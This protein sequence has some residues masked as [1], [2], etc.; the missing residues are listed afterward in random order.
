MSK[1]KGNIP[2]QKSVFSPQSNAGK[3]ITWQV[4][5][6][7]L[8]LLLVISVRLRLLSLPLERDEGQSAYIGQLLLKGYAPFELAY[9]MKFPGT[10]IMYALIMSVFGQSAAG[11]HAGLLVINL[12]TVLLMFLAMR[13]FLGIEIAVFASACYAL[14]TLSPAVL[15]SAA[16]AT[17]FCDVICRGRNLPV[18]CG[19]GK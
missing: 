1:G 13:R 16:H 9:N 12:G 10:S 4:I 19:P 17:H 2:Q 11:I 7:A 15:G 14:F 6:L 18:A 8:I 3:L 5:L